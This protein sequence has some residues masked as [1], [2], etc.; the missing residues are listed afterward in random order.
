MAGVLITGSGGLLGPYLLE[1]FPAAQAPRRSD[2]ELADA[3]A[4]ARLIA[5]AKPDTVVHAAGFTDVDGCEREPVRADRD[6]RQAAANLAGALPAASQLVFLSTDQVYPDEAGPHCEGGEAPVNAY[7]KSKLA[8]EAAVLRHPRGLV[9]RVNFFGPSRTQGRS[10][11]S[12]FV[13]ETL[14]AGRAAT[15]F[16][17]VLF[18]PLH[19]TTLAGLIVEAARLGLTGAFNLGCREGA[20][21]ADFALLLAARFGLSTATATVGESSALP[22]RAPRPKDLR[23]D[24]TRFE[25]ALGRSL[26]SLREEIAKL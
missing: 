24:V 3:G 18:S 14:R 9:L 8:G 23:M 1:A 10:S 26:P 13:I 25:S 21:K 20:S 22:G 12:D 16:R 5:A 17:D 4:V 11:L 15:F 6:N 19:M 7:G 2:C